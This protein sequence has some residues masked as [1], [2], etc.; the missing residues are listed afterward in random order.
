MP[1]INRSAL[2]DWNTYVSTSVKSDAHNI[3]Y[4][5]LNLPNGPYSSLDDAKTDASGILDHYTD[6]SKSDLYTDCEVKLSPDNNS[7]I[8]SNLRKTTTDDHRPLAEAGAP[9]DTLDVEF[10]ILSYIHRI[11]NHSKS[12]YVTG[13]NGVKPFLN[14]SPTEDNDS[15]STIGL[16]DADSYK[17]INDDLKE[18]ATAKGVED[19]HAG[20][21]TTISN[22][23]TAV[24]VED[25]PTNFK[26]TFKALKKSIS[27]PS[28]ANVVHYL[29]HMNM[30]FV[31]NS[32]NSSVRDN[33]ET[34]LK[35]V[36][37][38]EKQDGWSA[39]LKEHHKDGDSIYNWHCRDMYHLVD[40]HYAITISK[41]SS[42]S[43]NS[44]QIM[45]DFITHFDEFT[46]DWDTYPGNL[47]IG[48]VCK[49]LS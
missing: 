32:A 27:D 11:K 4:S 16:S 29:N 48:N 49:I 31:F 8:I 36:F 24:S 37:S 47:Y 5:C 17:T 44:V 10:N 7:L 22:F 2:S 23:L 20:Y 41:N 9:S 43:T 6:C 21:K 3:N 14:I 42:T 33:Y 35:D 18:K 38:T 12:T 19:N 15:L 28:S 30:T 39:N 34:Y 25:N 26:D 46:F 13:N 40:D 1:L 45:I